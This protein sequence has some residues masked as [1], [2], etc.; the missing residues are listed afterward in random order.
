MKGIVLAGGTGTRLHPVTMAVSK[1]LLP[2]YDKPLIY[3]PLSLLMLANIREIL[4]ITRPDEL[5]MF[6]N[7][8][9]DG[10]QWGLQLSY[11]VQQS[12]GGLAEAFLIGRAF[13]GESPVALVLG[14]NLLYGHNVG[15]ILQQ[16]GRN[17]G[18]AT[19]FAYPARDPRQFG[20]VTLDK[21]GRP[22]SIEEKPVE[23]QSN[24][25]VIGVY[26]Y[27]AGVAD[28]AARLTPSARGELEITDLN[29]AYLEQ[30]RLKVVNLGRGYAWF[31]AGTHQSLLAAS[32]F[33]HA[34]QEQQG[35][36][37]ACLEEIAFRQ[38]FIGADALQHRAETFG[39][40]SYG[41]YL[42]QLLQS[43]GLASKPVRAKF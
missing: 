41:D 2:V 43:G 22:L 31:D 25:A 6:Q 5:P 28:M 40:S 1:Q 8:L 17:S 19:V 23:P 24:L 34:V 33:V 39:Q 11:A 29:R 9:G 37:I 16:A 10:S 18:G 14:D 42:R 20:V 4:V 12:P 36:M 7:L 13:I 21:Q 38:G 3:Y 26:F 30:G 35:L 15:S 27:D 32:S